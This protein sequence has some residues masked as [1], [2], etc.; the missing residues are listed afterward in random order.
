MKDNFNKLLYPKNSKISLIC[1]FSGN[2]N[3]SFSHAK[4]FVKEAIKQ[5]VDFFKFQ[6]YTPDTITLDVNSKNFSI[7]NKKWSKF[8]NLYSLFKKSHTPWS[9]I[10]KLSVEL[11]KNKVSCLC[12]FGKTQSI[13]QK[14]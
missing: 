1:E 3:N 10:K 6:V 8:K 7:N 12:Q 13:F 14:N 5:K 4:K 2:H 9:W 11:N